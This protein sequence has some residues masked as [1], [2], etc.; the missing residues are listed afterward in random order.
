MIDR[1]ERITLAEVESVASSARLQCP[2][3]ESIEAILVGT[4]LSG[5]FKTYECKACALR[6]SDPMAPGDAAWYASSKVYELR[7]LWL[8]AVDPRNALSWPMYWHFRQ[9]LS[10]LRTLP[11]ESRPKLLDVGC[12]EGQFLYLA[13]QIG[14]EVTGVDFN[15]LSLEAAR[16]VFGITSLYQSSL[17]DFAADPSRELYDVITML[18][19]LEHT[20][21]PFRTVRTV[22][23]LLKPGGLLLVSVPGHERWPLWFDPDT[24]RPPHHLTLWTERSLSRILERGGL[25]V[26]SVRRKRLDAGDLGCHAKSKFK[27]ILL[28]LLSRNGCVAPENRESLSGNSETVARI[29]LGLVRL[30]AWIGL[31]PLCWV[32]KLNPRAGGFTLFAHSRKPS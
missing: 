22:V 25:K 8:R 31:T 15:S 23:K 17:E 28:R 1:K 11:L 5:T 30:C 3:C 20:A 6:F 24:D 2:A 26:A 29:P 4:H 16:R 27:L 32:L 12:G 9:V 7:R 18:E 19:V 13:K 14:F 21:N 10:V